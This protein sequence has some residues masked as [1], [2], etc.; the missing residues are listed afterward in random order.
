[1][2][3]RLFLMFLMLLSACAGGPAKKRPPDVILIMIDTLRAD[4][5]GCYG[6]DQGTSPNIDRFA[7]ESL[8]FENALSHAADTRLSCA[9]LM[10]G[11]LPHETSILEQTILPAEV[12]TLAE[13]L[14]SQDYETAAVISNYVLRDGQGF[15]QGFETFDSMMQQRELVRRWPERVAEHTTDR[16]IELLKQSRDRPLFLWVHYQDPHGPY[17]PPDSFVHSPRDDE[18]ATPVPINESLSGRGGIPMYQKLGDDDDT[19]HYASRYDGEVRYTDHHFARL[20]DTLRET[21]LYE[22]AIIVLSSDHGEGMGEH[23][24][25]FAHGEYLYQHQI[26]VPLIVRHGDR[27]TGRRSDYVQHVDMIPTILGM[28]DF[29]A[30]ESL[31]GSDLLQGAAGEASIV[32][33]MRSPFVDDGIKLSLVQHNLKVIYAPQTQAIELYDLDSD[34]LEVNDLALEPSQ[35]DKIEAMMATLARIRGEDRLDLAPQ[36]PAR[37]PTEEEL[38][39]LR[40]LGYVR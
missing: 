28:L 18:A 33:E 15:E 10:S 30:S 6:Y 17:A 1:M 11:Y 21:G 16:A 23:D 3:R 25:Y 32:S 40:S 34:P 20:L 13:I 5:L 22:N 14:Q 26:H 7:A 9:A 27:L 2:D 19:R 36:D 24:Y 8:V 29:P 4:R 39:N 31:R 12:P 38:E 35:A 37:E